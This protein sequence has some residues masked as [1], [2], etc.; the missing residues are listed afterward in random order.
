MKTR[1]PHSDLFDL[2]NSEGLTSGAGI[3]QVLINYYRENSASGG[4]DNEG[5]IKS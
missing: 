1:K 5:T 4:S 3:L 2:D